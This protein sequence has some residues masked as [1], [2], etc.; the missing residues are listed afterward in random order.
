MSEAAQDQQVT[1][2]R[3]QK[4]VMGLGTATGI[5]IASMIGMGIFTVTGLWGSVLVSETNL[6]LTWVIAAILALAGAISVSEIGAMRPHAGA[7]YLFN[8]EALGSNVGYLNGMVSIFIAFLSSMAAIALV[9]GQYLEGVI[10]QLP[11]PITAT[12]VLLVFAFVHG[13][14][15]VG[16][17]R[18]NNLLVFMKVGLMLFFILA[19][20][21][22]TR[23]VQPIDPALLEA[24]KA[25]RPELT[26]AQMP[27]GLTAEEQDAFLRSATGP[28]PLSAAVGLAVLG[29]T[30]AYAGWANSCV[31][32]GEVR[33][34][35]R[36]L[37][38]SVLGSVGL[39]AVIYLLVNIAYLRFIP[40]AAMLELDANGNVKEMANIGSVMATRIFGKVAGDVLA[41][42][43][44][45]LMVSTLST[46][47]MACGRV[48]TAMSWKGELPEIFGRL[49]AR[50]APASAMVLQALVAIPI[51]WISGLKDLLSFIGILISCM[52]C[53]T[54][55]SII[56]MRR[57]QPNAHRP[58]RIPLYPIPPLLYVGVVGWMV[59]SSALDPDGWKPLMA[60]AGA[61]I[62]LLLLKP[63][64][65]RKI[66]KPDFSKGE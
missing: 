34:P 26:L 40:P 63:I 64:V 19:G 39:V 25:Q 41:I 23:E 10:P 47:M 5:C 51:V 53:L 43:I 20:F 18:V 54:M 42:A 33:N 49:N 27:A 65:T 9:A 52:I 6:I 12:V 58:F 1:G 4:R 60:S 31:V 8:R 37:P 32:G 38:A 21:L 66:Q 7:Q 59:V 28:A 45:T 14:T 16:G 57:K 50:G 22:V 48:I 61:V 13:T 17:S 55:I 62:V 36:N 11:G 24:V 44:F 15:V 29:V 46:V 30:F 35:E 2:T 56:V 3:E